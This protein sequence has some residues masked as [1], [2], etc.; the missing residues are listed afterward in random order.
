MSY[1][2]LVAEYLDFVPP[3][4]ITRDEVALEV[5]APA[6][7]NII[8]ALTGVR[9]S[10]KTYR[11]YQLMNELVARG[12]PR[13]LIFYF[14]FDDDRLAPLDQATASQVLEAYLG[15]VPTAREGFYLLLDEV[16]EAPEWERFVRRVSESFK[17][18]IVITGSSSKL[19]S[20]DIPTHL[21]GRS[22]AVEMWPLS[23]AE[24][25][26]FHAIDR[27][28]RGGTWSG[29]AAARL[30]SAFD[31]YLEVGGFPAVQEL[32]P[33][34]RTQML[35]GYQAEIITKDVFE[36]FG[37]ASL[38]AGERFAR[39]AVRSTAL[40]FSVNAQ[41]KALRAA[42]V[43]TS[44]ASLYSL[45]EDLEDAHLLFKVSDYEL[46]IKENPKAAYKVYS[47][48]AGLAL[49]VA[50]A[51]HLD[52]GQRLETAVFIE[53]KRRFGQDRMSAICRYSGPGCPEVD[54]V[55]G[56]V[57]LGEQYQLIQVCVELGDAR[58]SKEAAGRVKREL[59]NL[60]SAMRNTGLTEGTIITLGEERDEK[61]EHGVV[62]VVPAWKWFL[63]RT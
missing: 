18:T 58:H 15:I 36:R 54:F 1:E 41:L 43:S 26:D 50:P 17:V 63:T 12:V 56:D 40:A 38:R 53:L 3:E 47:V 37:S 39:N 60:D 46:S 48:D 21:R 19:L 9:R 11:L 57:A 55:V 22:L 4:L 27:K 6:K 13:D 62:H 32:S 8:Y 23:F 5:P 31:K 61:T 35:Q 42:G 20:R 34:T 16:Q 24:Y 28:G 44:T 25:C 33:L 2:S 59:G 30:K 14:S 49:A 51:S 45:L 7:N 29:A 10:G 52:I